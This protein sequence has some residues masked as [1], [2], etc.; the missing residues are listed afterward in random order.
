MIPGGYYSRWYTSMY[1][2]I[3]LLDGYILGDY[4]TRWIYTRWLWYQVDM[5]LVIML[6]GGYDTRWI[7]TRWLCYQVD[8]YWVIMLPGGYIPGTTPPFTWYIPGIDT[9]YLPGGSFQR[10][11]LSDWFRLSIDHKLLKWLI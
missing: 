11:V 9:Q 3:K 1:L 10:S 7:Y 2:V 6:P 4:G 8:M 5:Y